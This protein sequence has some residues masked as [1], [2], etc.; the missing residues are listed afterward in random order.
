[1][2]P[3]P[4]ALEA[5]V[6]DLAEALDESI[7]LQEETL[8]C[9]EAGTRAVVRRDVAA[10][11]GGLEALGS[12]VDRL[13]GAEA[14]QRAAR[15]RLAEALGRP[16]AEATLGRLERDLPPT[17]ARRLAERRARLRDLVPAVR[18]AHLRMTL[19]VS[20]VSR[21]NRVL[22]A[23]FVP[24]SSVPQTYRTDG[25]PESPPAGSRAWSGGGAVLDA[26]L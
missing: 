7:R 15:T 1:M 6:K 14:R 20:E 12:L 9:L 18:R 13:R 25:K 23:A 2:T 19:L 22:L 3:A 11:E 16:G 4:G 17:L 10:I 8:T 5:A 21:L 24:E 26:R